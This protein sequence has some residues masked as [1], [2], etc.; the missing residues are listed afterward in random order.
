[1]RPY[2]DFHKFWKMSYLAITLTVIMACASLANGADTKAERT[3]HHPHPVH[4]T[5]KRVSHPVNTTSK[6]V[7][8]PV[9]ET[10][11]FIHE[12]TGTKS[13]HPKPE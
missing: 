4:A 5:S 7:H 11:L 8:H 2:E 13:R 1:M 3:T 9:H 12:V 10:S 6:I